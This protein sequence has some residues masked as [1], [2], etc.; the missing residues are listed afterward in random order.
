MEMI[1]IVSWAIYAMVV[2]INLVE[3]GRSATYKA[4]SLVGL[5]WAST[6]YWI[7][8]LGLVEPN[9]QL[10]VM[11]ATFFFILLGWP[12]YKGR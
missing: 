12:T 3:E 10:E 2:W 11:L 4:R 6:L 5:V 1:Y 9:E 7:V 8:L